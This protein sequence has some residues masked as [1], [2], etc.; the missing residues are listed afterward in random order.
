MPAAV[1]ANT[2]DTAQLARHFAAVRAAT[3]RLCESL[4]AEDC[5][6]QSMPEAS[7]VKWHLAHTSWFFETFI[8]ADESSYRPFDDRY[9]FLFNSYYDAMGAR[10]PRP[11]RGIV[12]RPSL[13]EVRDYRAAIDERVER[14]LKSASAEKLAAIEPVLTLGCHHEQQHQELILTDIQHALSQNV[15]RPAYRNPL[16]T[17]VDQGAGFSSPA[18]EW[19]SFPLDCGGSAMPAAGSHSTMKG[20]DT[21]FGSKLI[22]WRIAS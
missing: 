4:S 19:R 6:I 15:L 20:L 8:L 9:T 18:I 11:Q 16:A 12:S 5:Q 10:H 14:L 13:A 3:D 7:P 21:A 1:T 2:R 22:G 17:E